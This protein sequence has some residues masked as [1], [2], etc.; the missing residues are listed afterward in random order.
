[1]VHIGTCVGARGVCVRTPSLAVAA[2]EEHTSAGHAV[3][4]DREFFLQPGA[5]VYAPPYQ[6]A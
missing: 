5:Q 3:V 6:P 2:P 1:M 4:P